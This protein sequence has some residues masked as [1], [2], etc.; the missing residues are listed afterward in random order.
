MRLGYSIP[1]NQG[2][3]SVHELVD[4]AQFAEQADFDSV[5]ASEHL[6]HSSYIAAR[7]DNLPYYEPLTILTAVA[8]RTARVRLGTSVLVLPWH[9]PPRLAKTVATL[10]HLSAGRV[11]L[12]I[13]VATTEDEFENLGVNFKTRGRRTNDFLVALK[14]LWAQE[15]PEHSGEF[16]RYSGLKFSPKPHQSPHPPILVGGT[17]KAALRRTARYGNG[18]HALRHSP[19]Q[20]RESLVELTELS[21]IQGRDPSTLHVSISVPVSLGM[22]GSS[23]PPAERTSLKGNPRDMAATIQAYAEAGVHELVLSLSSRDKAA[24]LEMLA[25]VSDKVRPAL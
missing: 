1:S 22:A 13:G 10:D 8:M 17:S 4:L 18:W 6:F 2:F 3:E 11:D 12:G 23:R 20:I 25:Y 24:H 9:D 21:R 16:Y 15:T 7:L 5:W 19:A 14:A